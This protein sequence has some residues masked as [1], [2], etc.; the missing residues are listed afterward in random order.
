MGNNRQTTETPRGDAQVQRV[1][2]ALNENGTH[3]AS[4]HGPEDS[5]DENLQAL[6]VSVF[7]WGVAASILALLALAIP[8]L[9]GKV[10]THIDLGGFHLCSRQFYHNC[11]RNGESFLWNPH[12]FCGYYIHGEG[13][14]G[15]LHPVHYV[16]YRFFP[17]QIAFNLELLLCYPFLLGGCYLLFR[18]W[19]CTRASALVASFI[20]TFSGF[21]LLR[22]VHMHLVEMTVHL[23]WL[24]LAI[25]SA[26]TATTSRKRVWSVLAVAFLTASELLIGYPQFAWNITL[27]AAAYTGIL[28]FKRRQWALPFYLLAA[29]VLG[30]LI[31]AAQWLPS[32]EFLR[33]SDRLANAGS[34]RNA[35]SLHPLNLL[36]MFGPFTFK[37][38]CYYGNL[39]EFTLYS[40]VMSTLLL[41]WLLF[42][43]QRLRNARIQ[44]IVLLSLGIV[45]L[46]LGFGAYVN[47]HRLLNWVP[48][49]SKF[50]GPCRYLVLF[51]FVVAAL[52][53]FALDDLLRICARP[54][55]QERRFFLFLA[56]PVLA[57]WLFA[58]AAYSIQRHPEG[59]LY[60]YLQG[61]LSL[62]P[63][64]WWGPVAMTL[65]AV[66][67]AVALRGF[68]FALP[69]LVMLAACDQML[70]GLHFLHWWNTP[71]TIERFTARF[72][73]PDDAPE[74]RLFSSTMTQRNA[75]ALG[76]RSLANGLAGI[77][78]RRQLVFTDEAALRA[79]GVAYKEKAKARYFTTDD[80]VPEPDRWIPVPN[81]VPRVYLVSK[82]LVSA[83]PSEDIDRIDLSTTVLT[84]HEVALA[85]GTGEARLQ[86]ERNGYARIQVNVDTPQLLVFDESY[87]PG[88]KALTFA[89]AEESLSGEPVEILRVNGDFMG[90]VV[91]P[92]VR[93]VQ[94]GFDPASYRI[95]VWVSLAG[96]G[97]TVVC[98]T[99]A[100]WAARRRQT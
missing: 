15:F 1:A 90:V 3:N 89:G 47:L 9:T 67:V 42:R 86:E 52:S 82:V 96:I 78:P 12:L 65:C 25:D 77:L 29:I 56:V 37:D 73:T 14:A 27:A 23:P 7:R 70:Y 50:K 49:V 26:F 17:L 46:L 45:A 28:A 36:Q 63:L 57:S 69:L 19:S 34:L 53:A 2:A 5:S 16:L 98:F 58:L 79:A 85:E 84:E 21:A 93:E 40:G 41:M 48:V 88:W 61:D 75:W 80:A 60:T 44:V 31:G 11:L 20:F 43:F 91:E 94:F 59:Y 62:S 74:Q 54:R 72:R 55:Q 39:Q 100:F 68:R 32:Y 99:L 8:M 30:F 92:G 13:Q 38:G 81:P 33:D 87:H 10:Y 51:F 18:R 35:F 64:L 97:L 95:G 76:G 4:V 22:S 66:L 6:N 71:T 83:N 24:L